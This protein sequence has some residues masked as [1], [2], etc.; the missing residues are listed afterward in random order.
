MSFKSDLAENVVIHRLACE[1]GGV[2]YGIA[3]IPRP[4]YHRRAILVAIFLVTN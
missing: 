3:V 1:V 2:G 4:N